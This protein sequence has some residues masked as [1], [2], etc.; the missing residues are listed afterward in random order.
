MDTLTE[1]LN[2]TIKIFDEL[3]AEH[4]KL[5][6]EHDDLR[7]EHNDLRRESEKEIVGLKRDVEEL[8][9]SKDLWGNRAFTI[10]LA[11]V[12]CLLSSI[13]GG[14]VTSFFKKP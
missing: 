12:M 5:Q 14:I 10:S 9:K 11:I 6:E 4:K 13:L 3:R 2:N 1:R 7:Q 8:K